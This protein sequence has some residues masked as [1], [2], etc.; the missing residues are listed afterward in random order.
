MY[1]DVTMPD[2]FNGTYTS[3]EI[4][5]GLPKPN[6]NRS[7]L[8]GISIDGVFTQPMLEIK[9]DGK[10]YLQVRGTAVNGRRVFA[11]VIYV[12]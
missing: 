12:I 8:G 3:Y 9:T 7:F 4:L 6:T 11:T 10:I 1:I 2:N 5:A